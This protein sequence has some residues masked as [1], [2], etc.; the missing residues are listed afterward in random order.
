MI[1]LIGDRGSD[2]LAAWFGGRAKQSDKSVA[3]TAH[4]KAASMNDAAF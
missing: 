1:A 4:K 2:K 3:S